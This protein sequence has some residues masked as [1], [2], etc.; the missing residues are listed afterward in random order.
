MK[1]KSYESKLADDTRG[2]RKFVGK[3]VDFSCVG[4]FASESTCLSR[5]DR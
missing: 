4:I 1:R 3:N 2:L 5:R